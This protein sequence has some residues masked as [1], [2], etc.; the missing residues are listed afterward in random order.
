MDNSFG[1]LNMHPELRHVHDRHTFLLTRYLS[2]SRIMKQPDGR[3][4][5]SL[6]TSSGEAAAPAGMVGTQFDWLD[7]STFPNPFQLSWWTT[8]LHDLSRFI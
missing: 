5:I 4:R 6:G 2:L 8:H 3:V 7:P 1:P